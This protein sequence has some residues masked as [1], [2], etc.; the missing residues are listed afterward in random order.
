MAASSTCFLQAVRLRTSASCWLSSR[1]GVQF[2]ATWLLRRAA[3]SMHGSFVA[4][5]DN[6]AYCVSYVAESRPC[7]CTYP[8]AFAVS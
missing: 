7:H 1:N 4:W 5:Q 3:R 2:L 8:I 6:V